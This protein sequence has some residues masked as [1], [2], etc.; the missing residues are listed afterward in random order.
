MFEKAYIA[1]LQTFLEAL[2]ANNILLNILLKQAH[3]AYKSH[4]RKHHRHLN[5]VEPKYDVYE[6][7]Y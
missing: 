7:I 4:G 5:S 3:A 1:V 2:L 6:R